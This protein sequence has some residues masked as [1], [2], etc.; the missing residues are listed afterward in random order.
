MY[1]VHSSRAFFVLHSFTSTLYLVLCRLFHRDYAAAYTLLESLDIDTPLDTEQQW[2]LSELQ[3]LARDSHPDMHAC[4]VKLA[5]ALRFA[6]VDLPFKPKSEFGHYTNKAGHVSARCRLQPT[7]EAAVGAGPQHQDLRAGKCTSI[8]SS[9]TAPTGKGSA[10]LFTCIGR[11]RR[12]LPR[13]EQGLASWGFN[14]YAT[15]VCLPPLPLWFTTLRPRCCRNHRSVTPE[16]S[17]EAAWKHMQD[18]ARA[19]W[20]LVL[21]AAMAMATDAVQ[22][23][24]DPERPRRCQRSLAQLAV[25]ISYKKL[26]A[27]KEN[28][29]A[30][31]IPHY[32]NLALRQAVPFIVVPL[33]AWAPAGLEVPKYP[34]AV[35]QNTRSADTR[36]GPFPAFMKQL[37]KALAPFAASTEVMNLTESHTSPTPLQGST[38]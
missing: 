34:L 20:S 12:E 6:E 38:R 22:V 23:Y 10:T 1:R 15:G 4:R 5:L 13:I 28:G 36:R 31:S 37:A 3:H 26:Y 35:F 7:E 30:W 29:F 11:G 27:K 33:L 18:L 9:Y 14:V 17:G 21:G 19:G 32:S 2:L 16:I 24:F 25:W 8:S